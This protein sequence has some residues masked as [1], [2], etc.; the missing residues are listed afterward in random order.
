MKRFLGIAL[1]LALLAAPA[2]AGKRNPTVTIPE[3][4][5]VGST[6]IPA[7]DYKITWTG[8]G[9]SVQVTLLQKEK[10][11]ATFSARAITGKNIA[12]VSTDKQGGVVILQA[13]QL[14]DLSLVLEDSTHSGQQ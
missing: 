8:S 14:N 5:Q 11:V 9:P 2:F 7:G 10:T 1:T 3:T 12:G 4:V 6:T 13:I